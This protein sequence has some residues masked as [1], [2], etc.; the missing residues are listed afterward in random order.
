MSSPWLKAIELDV[1][2]LQNPLSRPLT[3]LPSVLLMAALYLIL[4]ALG[5]KLMRGKKPFDITFLTVIWNSVMALYSLYAFVGSMG[6]VLVN[7]SR[8]GFE[9]MRLFCDPSKALMENMDYWS[10]HFYLSKVRHFIH[11]TNP[12]P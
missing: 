10:F 8:V 1:P 3:S 7:W 12:K 6:T 2:W 5:T 9:P 11:S 4:T